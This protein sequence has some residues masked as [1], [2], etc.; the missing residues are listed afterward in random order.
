MENKNQ[1]I[2]ACSPSKPAMNVLLFRKSENGHHA[3]EALAMYK[4]FQTKY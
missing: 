2:I 4:E 1:A 3:I